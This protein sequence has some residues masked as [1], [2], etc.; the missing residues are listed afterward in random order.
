MRRDAGEYSRLRKF[1]FREL[2]GKD[3]GRGWLRQ[4]WRREHL[5][6]Y[7]FFLFS[8]ADLKKAREMMIGYLLVAMIDKKQNELLEIR[9]C[10]N[11]NIMLNDNESVL[12]Q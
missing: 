2:L 12:R 11:Q 4:A 7:S 9:R 10:L 5:F 1:G 8:L 6:F 3:S